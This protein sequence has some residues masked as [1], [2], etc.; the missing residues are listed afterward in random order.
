MSFLLQNQ[1]KVFP[2]QSS[3]PG[4]YLCHP[5][6]PSQA[7]LKIMQVRLYLLE[8]NQNST[9]S[10]RVSKR[11]SIIP[12]SKDGKQRKRLLHFS[13]VALWEIW[14]ILLSTNR[15]KKSGLGLSGRHIPLLLCILSCNTSLAYGI[16]SCCLPPCRKNVVSATDIGVQHADI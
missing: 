5:S 2:L 10:N 4:L 14:V 11:G 7:G 9:L 12:N 3:C 13:F 1:H 16:I 8:N 15:G 6:S